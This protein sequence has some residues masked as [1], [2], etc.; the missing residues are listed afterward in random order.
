MVTQQTLPS[1]TF[2][3]CPVAQEVVMESCVPPTFWV[4][5]YVAGVKSF[6]GVIGGKIFMVEVWMGF[7]L[8]P[9][10]KFI[11]HL[12]KEKKTKWKKTGL[13]ASNDSIMASLLAGIH[14]FNVKKPACGLS[15]GEK[16][17]Q[18]GFP[19]EFQCKF[20]LKMRSVDNESLE[21]SGLKKV[22][23][24]LSFS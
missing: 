4:R 14:D 1:L 18:A 24:I 23:K 8:I 3:R 13:L 6:C 7:R 12:K 11:K 15:N 19:E 21:I 10:L 9:K 16:N 20:L 5:D 2:H 22:T 17:A